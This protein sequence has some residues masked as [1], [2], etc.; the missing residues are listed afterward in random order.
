MRRR[1]LRFEP[2]ERR[3]LLAGDVNV[4]F[5]RGTLNVTG[6]GG[7][8]QIAIEYLGPGSFLITG[9]G[10]TTLRGGN[11][12][13]DVSGVNSIRVNM[14]EGNN[15]VEIR[16]TVEQPLVVARDL[17]IQSGRGNDAVVVE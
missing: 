4:N 2:L 15:L 7:D 13:I 10:A 8:N 17:R 11:D 6:D 5:S 12:P 3:L 14:R 9:N 1:N 16:G